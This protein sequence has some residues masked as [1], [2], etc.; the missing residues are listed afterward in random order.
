MSGP[1][2]QANALWTVLHGLPLR[3]APGWAGVLAILLLA[4]APARRRAAPRRSSVL[5]APVLAIAYLGVAY[6][7][8]CRAGSSPSSRRSPAWR[9]APS[10][11]SPPAT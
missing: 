11:P 8:S 4:L 5:T 10:A 2:V 3:S 9:S 1:E 6:S 7:R